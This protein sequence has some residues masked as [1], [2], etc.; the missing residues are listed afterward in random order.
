MDTL[1]KGLTY[2][3]NDVAL[4]FYGRRLHPE[5]GPL[6]EADGKFSVSYNTTT[7]KRIRYDH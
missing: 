6:T 3:K 7:E 5:R 1:S 2:N 4:N